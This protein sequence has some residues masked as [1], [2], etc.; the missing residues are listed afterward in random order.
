MEKGGG[1]IPRPGELR[2]AHG[3]VLFLYEA[4]SFSHTNG[5]QRWLA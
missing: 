1:A 4:G 5:Y 3:G 2:L